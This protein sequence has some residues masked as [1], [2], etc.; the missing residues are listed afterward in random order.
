VAFQVFI[1]DT[2]TKEEDLALRGDV[3][4]QSAVKQLSDAVTKEIARRKELGY[5]E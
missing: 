5:D 2:V 3:S 4:P 1:N